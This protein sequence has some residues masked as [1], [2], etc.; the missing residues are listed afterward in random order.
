M[1]MG[2]LMSI[3]RHHKLQLIY[4][5]VMVPLPDEIP[6][7]AYIFIFVSPILISLAYMLLTLTVMVTVIFTG[8]I[9]PRTL[10]ILTKTNLHSLQK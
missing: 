4:L 1:V 6:L 9:I 8:S 10:S 5:E 7:Q 3:M 2:L